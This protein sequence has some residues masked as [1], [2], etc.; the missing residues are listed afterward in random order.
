M[1]LLIQATT[2]DTEAVLTLLQSRGFETSGPDFTVASYGVLGVDDA[3]SLTDR[4]ATKP[5]SAPQRTFV[6]FA[7][8]VT[9]EAQ[10]ALLKTLEEPPAH[11]Q[12]VFVVSSPDQLLP[13][14]R[15]RME[16]VA[17]TQCTPQS[18]KEFISLTTDERIK[19][20][21][22]LLDTEERDM[23][24]VLA[25]LTELEHTLGALP[26]SSGRTQAL[27]ALYRARKYA[28]DKGSLLK[29]LLEQV[30]LLIPRL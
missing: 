20:I 28:G 14:V 19:K 9:I 30:A 29:P 23:P 27:T 2:S 13:T 8:G 11:A 17:I 7:S 16:R 4:A 10:N 6:C 12:F 25:F 3:R 5:L 18:G 22:E 15:S 1:P 24:S 21:Q 26:H